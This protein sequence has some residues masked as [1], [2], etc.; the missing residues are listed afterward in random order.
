VDG[1]D[2]PRPKSRTYRLRRPGSRRA[3]RFRT[4][5]ATPTIQVVFATW[6]LGT[7]QLCKRTGRELRT[8]RG[9]TLRVVASFPQELS[10]WHFSPAR[11][12]SNG[13]PFAPQKKTLGGTAK[14][15]NCGR[16]SRAEATAVGLLPSS[17]ARCRALRGGSDF[18]RQPARV[19]ARSRSVLRR[20]A[21]RQDCSVIIGCL[22]PD[23]Q[24]RQAGPIGPAASGER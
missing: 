1:L 17:P 4:Q 20:E 9:A 10:A 13:K 14:G 23:T 8:L 5:A 15:R 21:Y 2:P 7:P 18:P 3:P 22:A 19:Y 11:P 16:F 6:R 12:S 24:A